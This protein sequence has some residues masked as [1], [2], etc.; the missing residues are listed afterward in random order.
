M[1]GK[2][3]DIVAKIAADPGNCSLKKE[4]REVYNDIAKIEI[5]LKDDVEMKLMDNE[6]TAHRNAW[7]T[8]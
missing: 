3:V 7:R 2:N 1:R 4:L 8:H 5:E 6:K